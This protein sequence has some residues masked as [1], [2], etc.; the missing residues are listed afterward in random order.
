[1]KWLFSANPSEELTK[2]GLQY[3]RAREA[4]AVIW[5]EEIIS[6]SDNY[7]DP[8]LDNKEAH[9]IVARDRLRVEARKWVCCKYYPRVFGDRVE[10]KH[11]G[12][13]GNPIQV[14]VSAADTKLL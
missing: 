6:I 10:H 2:F 9:A 13:D 5:A 11:G 14:Q 4:Q 1:M 8:S 7:I 3:T 12:S